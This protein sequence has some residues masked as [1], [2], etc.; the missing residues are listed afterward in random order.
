LTPLAAKS[1][2]Y[3]RRVPVED[4]Q[5]IKAG[6]LLVEIVDDDYRAQLEQA[7]ANIAA[8]SGQR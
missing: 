4:F 1:P 3:V 5:K 2:G 6:D 7:R 8:P